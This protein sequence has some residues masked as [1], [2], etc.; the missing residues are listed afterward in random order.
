MNCDGILSINDVT[1]LIDYLLGTM[2][3]IFNDKA[4]DVD[5]D[6]QVS[7]GDVTGLIDLLLTGNV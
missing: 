1:D 6:G 4:A 2:P 3:K 7:I 5:L